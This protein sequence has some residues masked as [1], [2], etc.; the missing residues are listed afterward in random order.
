MRDAQE[1]EQ[2]KKKKRVEET[3]EKDIVIPSFNQDQ[4]VLCAGNLI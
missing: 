2:K 4:N 1:T 3:Q